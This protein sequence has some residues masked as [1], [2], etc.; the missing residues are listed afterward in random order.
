MATASQNRAFSANK[1]R[2]IACGLCVDDCPAGIIEMAGDVPFVEE[3]NRDDCIGC[4]HCLMVCPESAASVLGLDPDAAEP[5]GHFRPDAEAFAMLVRSRR[6][7]RKFRDEPVPDATLERIL[8]CA[9]HAPTGS[10]CRERRFVI[11]K[12]RADMAKIR[13]EMSRALVAKADALPQDETGWIVDMA[14]NWLETGYD[15]IFLE[16]PHMFLVAVPK[17]SHDA[18]VNCHI[19]MSYF[20]LAAWA[21]GVG[22][23]WCGIFQRMLDALP[24]FKPRLGIPDSHDFVYSMLFGLPAVKYKY[25]ADHR[26]EDLVFVKGF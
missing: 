18:V 22:T 10:N 11:V 21:N 8:S 24:E 1:D 13:D 7:V 9:A 20:D 6:S 4:Q 3:K 23:V 25:T 17:E 26:P 12:D 14:R 15:R 5:I 2:C 19:A 16:A